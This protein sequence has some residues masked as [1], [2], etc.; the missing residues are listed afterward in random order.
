M[1]AFQAPQWAEL[2]S[3][4]SPSIADGTIQINEPSEMKIQASMRLVIWACATSLWGVSGVAQAITCKP[5]IPLSRPDSRYE[6]VLGSTPADSEVRDKV[7]GLVW[8]RCVVGIAW[9]GTTCTGTASSL[10]WVNALD[11]ARTATASTAPN[12][13]AWRVPNHA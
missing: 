8:Q 13:T 5:S 7:T 3:A 9:N 1:W 2:L 6:A 4:C 11:A 12:A 10:T